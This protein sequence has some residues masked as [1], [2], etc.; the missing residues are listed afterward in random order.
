[1]HWIPR[2]RVK[3]AYSRIQS[4]LKKP[5][6]IAIHQGGEGQY[7]RLRQCAYDLIRE[8]DLER[9]FKDWEYPLYY[10]AADE[11]R[12]LLRSIGFVDVVI[13]SASSRG[14]EF[15][16]LIRDFAHAGLNPF[17]HKLPVGEQSSFRRAFIEKASV[18][19]VDRFSH[20][21]YVLGKY[22]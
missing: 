20:N 21:L 4:F 12:G 3:D 17:L 11:L 6:R 10:P 15:P 5:G 9:H 7:V 16:D 1:M 14:L 19:D 18:S 8:R 2:D 22:L 13:V